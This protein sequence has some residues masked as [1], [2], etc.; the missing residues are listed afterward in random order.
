MLQAKYHIQYPRVLQ[1]IKILIYSSTIKLQ[2][3][4]FKRMNTN[5]I[6]IIHKNKSK[7][8]KVSTRMFPKMKDFIV[9]FKRK[10]IKR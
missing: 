4:F 1:L 6:H 2:Q 10:N 7:T 5:F 8:L 9:N 3:I